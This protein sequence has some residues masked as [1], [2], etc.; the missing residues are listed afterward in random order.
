[1]KVLYDISVLGMGH[2]DSGSRSGIFRVIENLAKELVTYPECD[3]QF[4]SFQSV[5]TAISA[6]DYRN[7]TKEFKSI[8][9]AGQENSFSK[10]DRHRHKLNLLNSKL[11]T[12]GNLTASK[13]VVF[14]SNLYYQRLL[15]KLSH[16]RKEN[17]LPLAILNE[18]DIY[19]TPFFPLSNE[20][21][22][23]RVKSRF[24]TCY[25][26]I[27]IYRPDY[28]AEEVVNRMHVFLDNIDRETR[29]L[30]ISES[31]RNELLNYMGNRVDENK[32]TVTEL[33]AADFFYRS[34]D[35]QLN[36]F[37]REKYGIPEGPFILSLC[38]LEPRKNIEKAIEAYTMLVQQQH[39]TDLSLVLVGNKGFKSQ[40]MIDGIIS[41]ESIKKRIVITGFVADADL[42]PLYSEAIM[43]VY[44][45][46]YE[47]FGLPPLE[48][49]QCGTAV[50]TSNTTSLPEVVGN[51]GIM[52][53]PNDTTGICAAMWDIYSKPALQ[54][55][56]VENG[57][58]RAKQ[59]SWRRCAEKT[60]A[61][62][63]RSL[64][65]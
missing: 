63:Q 40:E 29:V 4:C 20:V 3:V 44:P 23:S 60:V 58:S 54:Q 30:C 35:K 1:M 2:Y 11:G 5:D 38:T 22:N 51:A 50:I 25:D 47:G 14:K 59:F 26:L 15:H 8:P 28:C 57:I 33:A 45:S 64:A 48:A 62:Y 56:L 6:I 52:I 19:H 34:M 13:K 65:D 61:A 12:Y 42:A 53:D 9:F 24:I 17:Y 18:T 31:A 27:P 43:F 41:D 21:K 32:V 39:L 36:S 55:Q 16:N 10:K 37:V 7:A 46:F 49:M